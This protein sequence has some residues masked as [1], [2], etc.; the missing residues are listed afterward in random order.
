MDRDMDIQRVFEIADDSLQ[1]VI[2]YHLYVSAIQK[3]ARAH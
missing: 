3:C 2:G 1:G